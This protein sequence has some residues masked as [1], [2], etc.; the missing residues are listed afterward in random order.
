VFAE[1]RSIV[2]DFHLPLDAYWQQT[3]KTWLPRLRDLGKADLAAQLDAELQQTPASASHAVTIL[4]KL[5][6]QPQIAE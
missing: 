5:R 6:I 1:A 4:D 3:L 2:A